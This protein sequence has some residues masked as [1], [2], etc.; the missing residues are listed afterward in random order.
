MWFKTFFV[1]IWILLSFSACA[2]KKALTLDAKIA[3]K[4]AFYPD[5]AYTQ[6]GSGD[7]IVLLH[8]LGSDRHTFDYIIPYLARRYSVYAPDLKGFGESPKPTDDNYSIYD[9]YLVIKHFLM[10]HHIQHPIVVGHSLGGSVALLLALDQQVGVKKLILID[11]PAYKQRLP[12]LLRYANIP[13]F[14]KIG[15]YL[16]PSRYEVKEGYRYAFYNDDKIPQERVKE[17]AKD[18][19]SQGAKYA[20]LTTNRQLIPD[21]LDAIVKRYRTISVSTLIVWGYN[22]IVVRRSKAYRLHRD[23]PHSRLRF[24]YACGHMPQEEK[25]QELLKIL[26]N[27]L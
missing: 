22:D 12:K 16:L 5:L 19:R 6:K 17:L 23:I 9:H 10:R 14:G 18:L 26:E 20:F 13:I 3:Q 15:F 2:Q 4:S 24:I 27:F 11:T 25:P 7:P 21:D 8:G 1:S